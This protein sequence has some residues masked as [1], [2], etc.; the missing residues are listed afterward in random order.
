MTFG[1]NCDFYPDLSLTSAQ[2]RDFYPD[3][4][5]TSKG[6]LGGPHI[7]PFFVRLRITRLELENG[8]CYSFELANPLLMPAP[9]V[10]APM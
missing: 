4:Q 7:H 9:G 10:C 2:I 5:M 6:I 3:F 1:Q 8:R